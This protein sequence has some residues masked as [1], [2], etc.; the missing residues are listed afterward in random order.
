MTAQI[1]AFLNFKGGV[2]K[3][4]NTVSIGAT[5]ALHPEIGGKRVLVVDMDPQC[6]STLW[7]VG[8]E[9]YQWVQ[10]RDQNLYQV[11]RQSLSRLR[12]DLLP[13]IHPVDKAAFGTG[14]LDLLPGSFSCLKLEEDPRMLDDNGLGHLVLHKALDTVRRQYDYIILDCPPAWSILTRNALRASHHVI[15]PYTPDYLALE[16]IKWMRELHA[17]FAEQVGHGNIG[18]LTAVIVNRVK[19]ASTHQYVNS[20]IQALSEL[21]QLIDQLQQRFGYRITVLDPHISESTI[22]AEAANYQESLLK[23]DP[24]HPVS[25]QFA[26]LTT[27]LL[28]HLRRIA[29]PVGEGR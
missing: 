7:L 6:N 22:V 20:Q 16:G 19:L 10:E 18:R 9:V 23:R 11:F 27:S 4:T 12:P 2:G 14:R 21:G 1:L 3:T 5:L 13:L 17:G 8:R 25:R 26:A 24:N 28:T 29:P 15:L